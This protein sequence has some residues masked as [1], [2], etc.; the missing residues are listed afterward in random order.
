MFIYGCRLG[1]AESDEVDD[2]GKY[3]YETVVG[4][5]EKVGEGEVGDSALKIQLA[6]ETLLVAKAF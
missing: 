3:L 4:G 5:L 1:F 2:V 6:R